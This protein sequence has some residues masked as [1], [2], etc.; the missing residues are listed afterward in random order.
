MPIIATRRPED[1]GDVALE[2]AVGAG[3]LPRDQHAEQAEPEELVGAELQRRLAEQRRHQREE[4]DADQR[5]E[6]RGGGGEPHRE[7][8]LALPRQ[9]I[10]VERR[11]G[12]GRRAGDVEQDRGAAAAVDRADVDA[13]QRQ[14]RLVGRHRVGEGDEQR[15]AHRRGQPRQDA[16]G[17]AEQRRP[18]DVEDRQRRQDAEQALAEIATVRRTRARSLRQPDEEGALEDEHHGDAGDERDRR[19]PRRGFAAARGGSDGSTTSK[20]TMKAKT[21]IALASQNG[22]QPTRPSV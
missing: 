10:A 15:H 3:H 17:D 11:R 20:V 16:D 8:G 19:A 22:S 14:D 1:A 13:H 18:G 5:A 7:P 4:E 9:R 2:R 12:A 6:R 21:K